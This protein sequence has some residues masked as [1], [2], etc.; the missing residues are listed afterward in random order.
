MSF[1]LSHLFAVVV[2]YLGILFLV[3]TAAERGWI[4]TSI[5]HHP[6]TYTLSLGVYATSWTYYGSVGFAQ[7]QGYAFLTIY[8]GVTLAFLLTP[9]LLRPILHLTRE[10]QLSSLADLFAFRYR[11]QLAGVLV[12]LFM[13]AGTLPYIALQIRAVT[14]SLSILT[15]EA[16][17]NTIAFGFC[18]TLTLFAILFGA[19]HVSPREKHAGL[20]AAI[21]FESLVKLSA[22]LVVMFYAIYGVFGGLAGMQT[23]LEQNPEALAQLNEPVRTAPWNTLLL[24]AFAAAFLLPRQFHMAFAENLNPKALNTASWALPLFLLLLAL[25]VPPVLWAGIASGADTPA[26]YYVLGI[27]LQSESSILPILTFIGGVSAASAMMIVTT[28]ALSTMALNHLL[29]PASYPDPGLDVYRWVL[30]GRRLL[31]GMIIA[32][33]YIFYVSFSHSEGLVQLGLLSFVAVAQFLPGVVGVLY[34]QRAT[35]AGFISGLTG[36]A[37]IW[38]MTLIG[39]LMGTPEAPYQPFWFDLELGSI[40]DNQWS[41][42]TFLSLTVNS[43]L[44]VVVSLFTRPTDGELEAAG[45]CCRTSLRPPTGTVVAST[46]EQFVQQLS[47]VLG[48]KTARREVF[49]ALQDLRMEAV[50]TRPSELRRLRERIERNLSGLIGPQLARMV[51]DRRLA[52]TATSNSLLTDSMRFMEEKLE[53]SRTRLQG[54]AAELDTLRR[55]QREILQQLP[56]GVCAIGARGEVTLWNNAMADISSIG[57]FGALSQEIEQLNFPWNRLMADFLTSPDQHQYKVKL[58]VDGKP[59]WLNLHKASIFG[60]DNV[61]SSGQAQATSDSGTV[62]LVEDLTGLH[63]LEAELAHSDR[64][65]SIGRLSAG[66]AHEIGN[67]LTGISS[68]AQNL[69][70]DDEPETVRESAE[71]IVEQAKRIGAIVQ[72]LMTFSHAG[73]HPN[74]TNIEFPIRP[75][76]T[77]AVQLV[78]LNRK[79]KQIQ[80]EIS[81]PEDL[82]LSGNRQQLLQILVNL[83]SN[84]ADASQTE[85]RVSIE[86]ATTEKEVLLSVADNGPGIPMDLRE[87][88]FEPFYT[89]KEPGEG[90]GLGLPLVYNLVREN[91]ASIRLEDARPGSSPPGTRIEIRFP[92]KDHATK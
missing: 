37:L 20:V 70:Y 15:Q 82:T 3:A 85:D 45:A 1:E 16:A 42:V 66:V 41:L 65:A 61:D 39:P 48:E 40:S 75:C 58:T 73:Q 38:S 49:H 47:R 10:Y 92:L 46:P 26:D 28:L 33:G 90:T 54:L 69:L 89:T 79:A 8:L 67:P 24:L 17:P 34:W 23:W 31:I 83:L 77:E 35:R 84:A 43:V 6:I 88:V 52:L 11:S 14:E 63:T 36:G 30:W 86:A 25:A 50:E 19:R 2:V 68:V 76:V 53:Q 56:I 62:L 59:R 64:L 72:A 4:P 12:T 18:V 80:F 29:L 51:V 22:L 91:D 57:R 13:L 44:F 78:S 7:S 27:T 81:V 74:K 21:A 32:A 87:Q 71:M 5:V 9:I 55:Y 60:I